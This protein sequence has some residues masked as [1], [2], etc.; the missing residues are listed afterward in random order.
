MKRIDYSNQD[1]K[2]TKAELF[3]EIKI[4]IILFIIK[5]MFEQEN[6]KCYFHKGENIIANCN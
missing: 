5:I 1:K 6:E 4:Y 2:V 3:Y